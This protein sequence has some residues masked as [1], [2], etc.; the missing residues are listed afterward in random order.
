MH[1]A[2]LVEISKR[3]DDRAEHL[4]YFSGRQRAFGQDFRENFAGVFRHHIM[5]FSIV[6]PIPAGVKHANEVGMIELR[7]CGPIGCA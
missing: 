5:E 3:V 4:L 6:K 1:Q 2:F 7:R